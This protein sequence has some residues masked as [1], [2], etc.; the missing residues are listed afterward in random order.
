MQ[1]ENEKK[2]DA[3]VEAV[4]L[5]EL[6]IGMGSNEKILGNE[7]YLSVVKDVEIKLSAFLGTAKVTVGEL[8]SM[9]EGG[10]LELDTLSTDPIELRF[11]GRLVAKG[12]LVVV[13]DNFGIQITEICEL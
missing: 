2:P 12:N 9:K 11:Q 1:N 7:K 3:N 8:F 6:Q 4:E 13:D 5:D 10:V